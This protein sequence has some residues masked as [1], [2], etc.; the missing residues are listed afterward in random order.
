M[1]D[2]GQTRQRLVDAI[3]IANIPTL[4]CLLLQLTGERR[5]IE[6]PYQ[7]TRTRGLDDN[8][9]GGL[10]AATQDEIRA[11]AI[12]AITE[13][14]DGK[15]PALLSPSDELLVEMMGVSLGETI[16]PEYG[17]MIRE[18]LALGGALAPTGSVEGVR[19]PEGLPCALAHKPKK[20]RPT[21]TTQSRAADAPAG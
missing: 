3:A 21:A 16:P 9:T 4:A 20:I 12:K 10:P 11:A 6:P 18:E 19:A 14:M 13:W 8:D 7:P 15:A 2:A 1:S 17:L 5:W